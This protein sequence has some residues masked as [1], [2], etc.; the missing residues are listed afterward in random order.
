MGKDSTRT[1]DPRMQRGDHPMAGEKRGGSAT[2]LDPYRAPSTVK[3]GGVLLAAAI[4]VAACAPAAPVALYSSLEVGG[5]FGYSEQQLSDTS[6]RVTYSAPVRT[7]Y[8]Y[9][10]AQRKRETE[11]RLTLAYDLALWRAAEL[12][13]ANGYKAFEVSKQDADVQVD[14]RDDYDFGPVFYNRNLYRLGYFPYRYSAYFDRYARLAAQVSIAVE[15]RDALSEDA[16]DAESTLKKLRAKYPSA[17][18]QAPPGLSQGSRSQTFNGAKRKPVPG[19][20]G[21]GL[22][23]GLPL[24]TSLAMPG[25]C[26]II[27][28]A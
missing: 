17:A 21:P 13:L 10:G 12:A 11:L 20:R 7:T 4:A 26:I 25:T 9:G 23:P 3:L 24:D 15:F 18:A 8:A 28:I 5:T 2:L 16:F 6:Y 1:A 14:I 27:P 22:N 19:F